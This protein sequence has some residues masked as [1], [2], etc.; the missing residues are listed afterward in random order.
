[1]T[2]CSP[3]CG[4][5]ASLG[6]SVFNNLLL[7]QTLRAGVII[8][9]VS[10]TSGWGFF[11]TFQQKNWARCFLGHE[12]GREKRYLFPHMKKTGD[13]Y[14][15][16]T[17]LQSRGLKLGRD[18]V[19]VKSNPYFFTSKPLGNAVS[20]F[21]RI[22]LAELHFLILIFI[23]CIVWVPIS[24]G[25]VGVETYIGNRMQIVTE[26]KFHVKWRS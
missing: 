24:A 15:K 4:I 22:A 16:D 6:Y 3:H 8:F 20:H 13:F 9:P 26:Q 19:S 21:Y 23:F 2:C 17:T 11:R 18:M 25:K 12:G 7:Q 10:C 1:M 14:L 5:C